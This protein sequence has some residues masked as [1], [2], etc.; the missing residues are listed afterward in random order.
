CVKTCPTGAMNYGDRDKMV[1][2]ANQRLAEAKSKFPKA[3]VTGLDDLRCFYL[4]GDDPKKYHEY[5]SVDRF[6]G[7]MDRKMALKKI[8]K[9]LRELSQEWNLLHKLVG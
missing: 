9:S 1:S 8:G 2:L 6:P 3:V 4:L 7:V 5:A